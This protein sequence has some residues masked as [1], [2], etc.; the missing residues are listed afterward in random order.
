MVINNSSKKRK[1]DISI[2]YYVVIIG[3]LAY[4]IL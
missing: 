1:L 2:I 4:I 3:L